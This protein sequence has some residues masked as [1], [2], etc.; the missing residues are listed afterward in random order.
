MKKHLIKILI[1]ISL[2]SVNERI[3]ARKVVKGGNSARKVTKS[4]VQQATNDQKKQFRQL[5]SK[6]K[7]MF[8][9][10]EHIAKNNTDEIR[11]K[12]EKQI[13][14][15]ETEQKFINSLDPRN[16]VKFVLNNVCDL[17][18]AQTMSENKGTNPGLTLEKT[19]KEEKNFTDIVQK[20]IDK[21][22]NSVKKNL[23][24]SVGGITYI[25][26]LNKNIFEKYAKKIFSQI[27]IKKA[28]QIV[29]ESGFKSKIKDFFSMKGQF[30][31]T[32]FFAGYLFSSEFEKYH[33]LFILENE[34]KKKGNCI[35][36]LQCC[37]RHS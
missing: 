36:G 18:V 20:N 30:N 16:V 10:V 23:E 11:K 15:S 4:T 28:E 21:W 14:F 17:Q 5:T 3:I 19:E 27:D 12:W 34:E 13:I 29:E 6:D 8:R 22:N 31:A 26:A 33:P 2:I 9:E 24:K 37:N 25:E 35:K 32:K 1:A 7:E